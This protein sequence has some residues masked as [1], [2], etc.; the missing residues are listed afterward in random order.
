MHIRLKALSPGE[1]TGAHDPEAAVAGRS[2][3]YR[4]DD[5][6]PVAVSSQ[7]RG[8]PP[9]LLEKGDVLKCIEVVVNLLELYWNLRECLLF[10]I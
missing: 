7:A 5:A 3:V 6:I 9:P 1:C 10:R 8:Q 2:R 4:T